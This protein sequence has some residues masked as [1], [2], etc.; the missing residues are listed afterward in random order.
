[1][2]PSAPAAMSS[3]YLWNVMIEPADEVFAQD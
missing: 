3:W 2:T 1:M